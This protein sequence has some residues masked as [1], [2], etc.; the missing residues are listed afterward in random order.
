MNKIRFGQK[1]LCIFL[2]AAVFSIFIISSA[3]ADGL[4]KIP[5]DLDEVEDEDLDNQILRVGMI[6]ELDAIN[7]YEQMAAKAK[8]PIIK[9]VLLDIAREEKIHMGEF[10]G[11]LIELDP[12]YEKELEEGYKEIKELRSE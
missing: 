5:V 12:E 9:K 6:A 1:F 8:N 2:F 7:L 4:S 11:L 10:Q 3:A